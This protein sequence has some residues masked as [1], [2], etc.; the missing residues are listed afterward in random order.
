MF[1]I[2]FIRPET[3]NLYFY[4]TLRRLSTRWHGTSWTKPLRLWALEIACSTLSKPSTPSPLQEWGSTATYW[5]PAQSQMILHQGC[6]LSPLIFVL[7]LE[8]L[9]RL[10][11][12]KPDTKGI[13][14]ADYTDRLAAFTEM[15]SYSCQNPLLPSLTYLRTLPY[16]NL[17]RTYHR[18]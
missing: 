18:L 14:I 9:L 17:W 8:P 10:I 15:S 11:R 13:Q 1:S 4:F 16:L 6:P 5:K 2:G 12:M 3:L 7:T